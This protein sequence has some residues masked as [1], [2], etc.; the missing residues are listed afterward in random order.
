MEPPG[1]GPVVTVWCRPWDRWPGIG[2]WRLCGAMSSCSDGFSGAAGGRGAAAAG[3]GEKW[4]GCLRRESSMERPPE[5]QGQEDVRNGDRK[6]VGALG[7]GRAWV[8]WE[9]S[10]PEGPGCGWVGG[11]WCGGWA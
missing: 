6:S 7:A 8:R 5:W 2:A 1:Q 3:G 9:R 10:V 4:P 11:K